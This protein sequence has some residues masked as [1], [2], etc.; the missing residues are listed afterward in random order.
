VLPG[1]E[2]DV[3]VADL[4]TDAL[5][6]PGNDPATSVARRDKYEMHNSWRGTSTGCWRGREPGAG[7]SCS[8]RRRALARIP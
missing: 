6:L 3:I 5:G 8:S 7:R 4:V 2:I 1:T